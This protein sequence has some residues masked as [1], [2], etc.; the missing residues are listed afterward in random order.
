MTGKNPAWGG[1]ILRPEATGYGLV[2]FVQKMLHTRG[3]SVE[4]K[5][6]LIS[7]SGN[8]AQFAAEKVMEFGGKVVSLSDSSGMIY[9]AEGLNGT[10]L[11]FI[12]KLKNEKRGRIEE[13]ADAFEGVEYH[14]GKK[15]WGIKGQI[16][17]PCATQNEVNEQDV[18]ELIANGLICLAE[19]ANK[20][21]R[22]KAIGALLDG[23]ILYG[24]GKAANAGGVAVS[25]MEMGQNGSFM[26]WSREEVDRRLLKVMHHIHE[27]CLLHGLDET[28]GFINYKRGA[29]R[30]AFI[31][32]ADAMIQQGVV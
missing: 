31:K 2:Y 12:K 18:L 22:P 10:K 15:P 1:S 5:R 16:A 26:R 21:C 27:E 6:V 19:G 3:T 28:S 23:M 14:A 17:L 4:G 25:G 20:P 7:G 9:D 11:A 8:V 24:P 29:N 30:A 32:V 13:Y